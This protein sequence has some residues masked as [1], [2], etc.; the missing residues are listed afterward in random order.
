MDEE[1]QL[2]VRASLHDMANV[3]A[4]VRGILDLTQ[5]G[6]PLSRRDRERLEAVLED[7]LCTLERTRHLA[8]GTFPEAQEEEGREWRARLGEQLA[9]MSTLFRCPVRVESAGEAAWDRWPGE[10]LRGFARAVTRQVISYAREEGLTLACFAG[11]GEWR[12]EWS[13]ASYLPEALVQPSPGRPGDIG[14]RWAL[15]AGAMLKA[16]LRCDGRTLLARIPR[17]LDPPL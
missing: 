6:Q 12:L 11:A 2:L 15:R 16:D 10:L 5:A 17:P 3:L 4:G 7:G 9:P 8:T 13:P 14:T 1:S